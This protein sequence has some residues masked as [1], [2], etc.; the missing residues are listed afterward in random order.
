[1]DECEFLISDL[2]G[3]TPDR[4]TIRFMNG[5]VGG[6][7]TP[8]ILNL[9][10]NE[11]SNNDE[12]FDEYM[13]DSDDDDDDDDDDEDGAMFVDEMLLIPKIVI[14]DND[15]LMMD[16][17]SKQNHLQQQ[18]KRIESESSSSIL[19]VRDNNVD[20]KHLNGSKTDFIVNNHRK[21]NN[22]RGTSLPYLHNHRKIPMRQLDNGGENL[23]KHQEKRL[24]ELEIENKI[25][26][27]RLIKLKVFELEQNLGFD[28]CNEV[29][30]L[31][32]CFKSSS[33]RF[34]SNDVVTTTMI[35]TT[36]MSNLN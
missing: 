23:R 28:H 34:N 36:N 5:G 9:D 6:K 16:K 11:I 1:M 18:Q 29:R 13:I 12:D 31:V 10:S 35:S 3:K 20:S 32:N 26:K 33:K 24:V 22:F 17:F 30:D 4:S 21:F 8:S 7:Q 2:L 19:T 27:N 25:L 14:D 15:S